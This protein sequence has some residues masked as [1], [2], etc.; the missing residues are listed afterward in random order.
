LGEVTDDFEHPAAIEE[1]KGL[2]KCFI[3]LSQKFS[4][5]QISFHHT[6]PSA[7]AGEW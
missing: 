6:L 2:L 3:P 1:S 4:I 5:K 7:R